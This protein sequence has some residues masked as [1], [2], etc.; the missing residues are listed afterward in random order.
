MTTRK[1]G[2]PPL[3][4]ADPKTIPFSIRITTKQYD[5]LYAKAARDRC[6]LSEVIRRSTFNDD[7]SNRSE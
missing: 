3:D 1:P 7:K 5:D 6:S 2:R 4:D